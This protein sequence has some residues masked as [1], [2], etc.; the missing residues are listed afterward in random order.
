MSTIALNSPIAAPRAINPWFIA[1][2]VLVPTF[3]EVLD[4][5]I[6]KVALLY[7]SGGLSTAVTDSEW[8]S[9]H[10]VCALH[11]ALRQ[12]ACLPH[13]WQQ[14]FPGTQTTGTE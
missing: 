10:A 9:P 1:A 12:A 5:T 2:A 13:G 4:T 8:V 11:A 3:M 6:A 7:I 14:I